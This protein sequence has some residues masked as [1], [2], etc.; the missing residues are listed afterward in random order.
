LRAAITARSTS[1]ASASL[2]SARWA[3]LRLDPFAA[4]EEAMGLAQE[5]ADRGR[6]VG[7]GDVDHAEL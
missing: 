2:T 7:M 3:A 6:D 5:R 1:D 4:D